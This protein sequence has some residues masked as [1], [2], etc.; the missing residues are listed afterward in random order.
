MNA[1]LPGYNSGEVRKTL[2][3]FCGGSVAEVRIINAFGS[4]SR[5]DA[6]YFSRYE[7]AAGAI[8]AHAKHPKNSGIYFVLNEF[9]ADLQNRANNRIAERIESTV[10]DADIIRR[11]WLFID[12]DPKRPAGI[13]SSEAEWLAARATADAVAAFLASRAFPA[14]ILASSGNGWHLHYRIDVESTPEVTDTVRRSLAALAAKFDSK[15][16]KVYTKVFNAGR[17]CKLYGTVSRKGDHSPERPHRVSSLERVP[18]I[19]HVC[20]WNKIEALAAE[21]PKEKAKTTRQRGKTRPRKSVVDRA[22]AYLAKI[23][24]AVSGESGHDVTFHAACV[25]VRDFD[26]SIEDALPIL[27]EWN[28]R[29][30][31]PWSDRELLHKLTDAD[32]A[33]GERGRALQ[34]DRWGVE[35]IPRDAGTVDTLQVQRPSVEL[36]TDEKQVVDS[37]L[38]VLRQR[39]DLF[40]VGGRLCQ[41]SG[42]T[43]RLHPLAI[44]SL[45]EVITSRVLFLAAGEET[46]CPKFVPENILARF[47]LSPIPALRRIARQPTI[48][49]DGTVT[50][51]PGFS[52]S[53]GVLACFDAD[54]WPDISAPASK[55]NAQFAIA[56]LRSI[57]SEF[58]WESDTDF[59]V[60]CALVFSLICRDAVAGN[61]PA[62]IADA[63]TPGSGK[64]LLLS[65]AYLL[66]TGEQL[67]L[68]SYPVTDDEITKR[69]VTFL[70]SAEKPAAVAFD[71]V[72]R[73]IGSDCVE[74]YLTCA[75]NWE[76]RL[77]GGNSKLSIPPDSIL[78]FSGNNVSATVDLGRRVLRFRLSPSESPEFRSDFRIPDLLQYVSKNRVELYS[79]CVVAWRAFKEAG[80]P[81]LTE[82]RWGSF[83][84]FSVIRSFLIWSG[85]GDPCA[86]L[87]SQRKELDT[88][89]ASLAVFLAALQDH[90]LQSRGLTSGEL[91]RLASDHDDVREALELVCADS[92]SKLNANRLGQTLHRL[93]GRFVDGRCLE[94]HEGRARQRYWNV[95]SSEHLNSGDIGDIGD[96]VSNPS[97]ESEF[98]FS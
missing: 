75:G 18:D 84:A 31:P 70:S 11:R 19:I 66:A 51:N 77:L 47:D 69:L 39:G 80:S 55:E 79:L 17:V 5:T 32:R 29:C 42:D 10:S 33:P 72:T 74:S 21:A 4:K 41:L 50:L 89:T 9:P 24:P 37:V 95:R 20:D 76:Q 60:W 53:A 64:T 57:V 25:L 7:I 73:R 91:L 15:H 23:P 63:T 3:I 35:P 34:S 61:C 22:A 98:Q 81:S 71:N 2:E 58:S 44:P 36:S 94:L 40:V 6:G 86:S 38:E 85:A 43:P 14:P 92:L 88:G 46:R 56:T 62:W 90:S 78:C 97:H 83:E 13:S 8:A 96:I 67:P 49:P 93:K 48:L 26:L 87:R 54:Q 12:V 82:N 27:A 65:C 45:R 30:S 28:D 16:V 68:T 52:E 1:T 59:S